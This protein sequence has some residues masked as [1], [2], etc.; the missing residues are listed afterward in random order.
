MNI[1]KCISSVTSVFHF[2][3]EGMGKGEKSF[4]NYDHIEGGR[5]MTCKEGS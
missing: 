2:K 1:L 4:D 3:V 5:D